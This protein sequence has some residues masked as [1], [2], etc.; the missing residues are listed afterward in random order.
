[1]KNKNYHWL[2]TECKQRNYSTT[3][4]KKVM[5]DRMKSKSIV[6]SAKSHTLHKENKIIEVWR[7][8]V[9]K[10]VNVLEEKNI[11]N[12]TN[13]VKQTKPAPQAKQKRK[14]MTKILLRITKQSSK[15]SCGLHA[16]KL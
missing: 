13:E 15:R 11:T 14:T 8:S 6:N 1:M 7:H 3:K 16:L 9:V 5:P 10:E 12:Q 2:A 4:D